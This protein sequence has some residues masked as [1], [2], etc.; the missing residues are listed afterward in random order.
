MTRQ[1][2]YLFAFAALLLAAGCQKDGLVDESTYGD[3]TVRYAVSLGMHEGTKAVAGQ[4]AAS[5]TLTDKSGDVAIPL[6]CEVTD[7]IGTAYSGDEQE[8]STKGALIN[9]TGNNNKALAEFAALIDNEFAAKAYNGTTEQLSQTVT[10]PEGGSAWVATPVAY[11]PQSTELTFLACAN[12]PAEDV[13]FAST[14]L[15]MAY[16]VPETAGAQKDILLGHYQGK[17]GNT[18]TAQ[19]R[20][21]HPLTAVRFLY[22]EIDGN[23]SVKSIS[24]E[25][26][27]ASGTATMAP[28]GEIGWTSV[29][30]YDH[31]VSQTNASGLPL[32]TL[33]GYSAKL[34]G[35]PF[36]IIPQD[37]ESQNVTVSVVFTDNT[38][39]EAVL[40]AGNWVEGYTNTYTLSATGIE[41]V[42]DDEVAENVKSNLTIRNN[43][44]YNA[45]VRALIVGSWVNE[46][47]DI[48]ADW[49]PAD[50]DAGTFSPAIFSGTTN[51]HRVKGADGFFYYKHILASLGTIPVSER[52][53]DTYTAIESAKPRGLSS[54][55][56]LE[57]C[58]VSQAVV[59]D[60]DKN[61]I[62]SAWG[63]TAAG[64]VD[65]PAI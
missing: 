53:F 32:T 47:G 17:G 5:V 31:S 41:L 19:I 43:G 13:G 62:T 55:D 51:E 49:D 11:W 65:A 2:S 9:T 58:I 24:L 45:Y 35:E 25:G 59:A 50:T 40:D 28:D 30:D 38:T 36:I 8:S 26:V 23:P 4:M 64:Y 60:P 22:G 27:A 6:Q 54:S 63:E 46:D 12:I 16:T 10:W 37:L 15:S 34:I 7:G 44:I 39:V 42:I 20:F 18:G 29:S 1:I 33:P 57:I 21:E 61:S 3:G 48:V 56:H 52:L 14:G